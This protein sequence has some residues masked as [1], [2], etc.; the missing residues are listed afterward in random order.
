MIRRPIVAIIA[1]LAVAAIPHS[2]RAEGKK[3]LQ[4]HLVMQNASGETGTATML[5]GVNG[6][7]VHLRMSEATLVQPAHIHKGTCAN[8][9]PKPAYALAAVSVGTSQ[10][11][12]ANLTTS[13]LLA[14]PYAINVH[15]S[16]TEASLYVACANILAAAR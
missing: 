15:K 2:A 1:L 5:D 9:N 11:T 16:G 3:P 7:I 8:L 14:G 4:I 6:L 10:T 13:T 12:I